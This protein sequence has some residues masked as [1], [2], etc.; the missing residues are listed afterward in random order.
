M[1]T[2]LYGPG[3]NYHPQNSHVMASFIKK[4]YEAS[5][6]SLPSVTCWGTGKPLREFLHVDDLAEAVVFALENWDPSS[7]NAPRDKNNIPL[8]ILNVGTGK[9]ISIKELAFKISDLFNYKGRIVWDEKK[10]DGTPRKLLNI[11]KI[12]GLG[13][14]P[15]I[16]LEEGIK[17][18]VESFKTENIF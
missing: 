7:T 2:N 11:E 18:A 10:P 4:F 14:E 5:I 3:D 12:K 17:A 16:S 13:W 6:S 1:P 8:N 9:E 15:K